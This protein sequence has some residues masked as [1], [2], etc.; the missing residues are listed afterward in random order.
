M[1][2]AEDAQAWLDSH[3]KRAHKVANVIAKAVAAKPSK[4]RVEAA[5]TFHVGDVVTVDGK[6]KEWE[7]TEVKDNKA[8]QSLT[9]APVSGRGEGM[10][11]NTRKDEIVR[12]RAKRGRPAKSA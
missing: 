9:L 5:V 10:T 6:T 11:V 12:V 1:V 8:S 3:R 4:D 2:K 7:V